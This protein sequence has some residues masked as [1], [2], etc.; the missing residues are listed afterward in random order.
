MVVGG[1]DRAAVITADFAAKSTSLATKAP[2]VE[3]HRAG[4]IAALREPRTPKPLEAISKAR[5]LETA[6]SIVMSRVDVSE[7]TE[8]AVELVAACASA[9]A[10]VMTVPA[11]H[12]ALSEAVLNIEE[13]FGSAL[14][15]VGPVT[16]RRLPLMTTRLFTVQY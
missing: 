11:T 7:V 10:A 1:G 4:S 14:D 9:D 6:T 5:F 12:A 15:A 16:A 8:F 3:L 2:Y 13:S